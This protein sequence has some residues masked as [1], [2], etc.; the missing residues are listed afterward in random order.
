MK[1]RAVILTD[2]VN[3]VH[4]IAQKAFDLMLTR[5]FAATPKCYALWYAY[6][7]KADPELQS[8]L[9]KVVSG[10]ELLTGQRVLDLYGQFF[11][12][13]MEAEA[14]RQT[15]ALIE[16]SV[17]KVIERLNDANDN[18]TVYGQN[19]DNFSGRLSRGIGQ[20][21]LQKIVG[22]V[23]SETRKM[24]ERSERIAGDIKESSLEIVELRRSLESVRREAHTDA[25]T[26]IANRRSFDKRLKAALREAKETS[27]TLS[28][29][30]VDIDYFKKF[31]DSH[32]HQLGDKVL[33]L[34]ARI[35]KT[36]IKGR[37][38]V[39]R[40][41]GEEF[42]VILPSTRLA[43][44]ATLA[45]QIREAVAS[46][47]IIQ[48]RTGED[49]GAITLS[50]GVANLRSSDSAEGLVKRADDSLYAAKRGGRNRVVAEDQLGRAV[51]A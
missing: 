7:S 32:G 31:N 16:A 30:M 42:A 15:G 20:A 18:A 50:I 4:E 43:G 19:L 38:T 10:S 26:G 22:S 45:D 36:S 28:L 2:D 34:V 48:K 17:A 11:E 12:V 47:H 8:V 51:S 44:A 35:L 21:E 25:L 5:G 3:S 29:L 40:Y 1:G 33:Q 27:D 49:F 6:F 14:V 41:G 23:M 37:D 13:D 24:K 46:R 9:D 39:A